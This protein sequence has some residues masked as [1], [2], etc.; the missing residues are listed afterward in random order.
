MVIWKLEQKYIAANLVE[1]SIVKDVAQHHIAL[2]VR[3][4]PMVSGLQILVNKI[5]ATFRPP[6]FVDISL[7]TLVSKKS[8]S[9]AYSFPLSYPLIPFIVYIT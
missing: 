6:F 8:R 3:H 4:L 5:K 1:K 7:H 9:V 2:I